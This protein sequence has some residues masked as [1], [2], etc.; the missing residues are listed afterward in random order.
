[1]QNNLKSLEA[2]AEKV[3]TQEFRAFKSAQNVNSVWFVC[4]T[5]SVLC[6]HSIHRRKT[7]MRRR[8]RF[9]QTS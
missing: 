1:M 4:L 8:L 7:S 9:L 3:G 6:D 2:Q 5:L